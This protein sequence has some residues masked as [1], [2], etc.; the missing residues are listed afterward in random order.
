MF[1]AIDVT[2][3]PIA[4]NETVPKKII[5]LVIIEVSYRI[6]LFHD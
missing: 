2:N 6:V 5:P 1:V 3:T 4:L